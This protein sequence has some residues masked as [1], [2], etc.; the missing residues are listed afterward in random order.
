M[1]KTFSGYKLEGRKKFQGLNISIENERGSVRRGTDPNG[2]EWATF[3]HI[4]YGYIRTTEGVDGDHVDCYIGTDSHSD[5]VFI[6]HQQDPDTKKYDED[7][8]M[9]GF[10]DPETALKAYRRQYDRPGYDQSMDAVNMGTFKT[11]LKERYG[12]KLKPPKNAETQKKGTLVSPVEKAVSEYHFDS[13]APNRPTKSQKSAP[14]RILKGF[15]EGH[16]EEEDDE[17]DSTPDNAFDEGFERDRKNDE[18]KDKRPKKYRAKMQKSKPVS[19]GTL[20]K[21]GKHVK[22]GKGK[23][24]RLPKSDP[25]YRGGST[26]FKHGEVRTHIKKVPHEA[27]KKNIKSDIKDTGFKIDIE[28]ATVSNKNFRKVI[29]TGQES[30]LVLMSLKPGEEIGMEVHPT[31]DQFFR[32]DGG[33]GKAIIGGKGRDIKNG[34]AFIAPRG[35]EHNVIAGPRGLKL[36]TI[37]SPANYKED[38]VEKENMEKAKRMPV[39]TVSH[40]YQKVAEGKWRRLADRVQS[41]KEGVKKTTTDGLKKIA[42]NLIVHQNDNSGFSLN[43][44]LSELK[45]RLGNVDFWSFRSDIERRA[46]AMGKSLEKAYARQH[47]VPIEKM[48][49]RKG[50]TFAQTFWVSREEAKQIEERRKTVPMEQEEPIK[51][52]SKDVRFIM[53]AEAA[54]NYAPGSKRQ[55]DRSMELQAQLFPHG[56][57][58]GADTATIMETAEAEL[59]HILELEERGIDSGRDWYTKAME[60]TRATLSQIHP[61]LVDDTEWNKLTVLIAVTSPGLKPESNLPLGLKMYEHLKKTGKIPTTN[62]EGGKWPGKNVKAQLSIMNSFARKLGGIDQF[63]QWLKQNSTGRE[64]QSIKK[65]SSLKVDKEYPNSIIFGPKVG[66]F[67]RNMLGE[68]QYLTIDRW[69]ARSFYRWSNKIEPVLNSMGAWEVSVKLTAGEREEMEYVLGTLSEEYNLTMAETQAM[70]WYYE[71]RLYTKLKGSRKKG[72]KETAYDEAANKAYEDYLAS[73]NAKAG[74]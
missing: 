8:V 16:Y 50:K 70:L 42:E 46:V 14:Q 20:S 34:D 53:E 43:D 6:V 29:A 68:H 4:P 47:L 25:R 2:H 41:L 40:G 66:V 71:K 59:Q 72:E 69:A 74:G 21:D 24:V 22:A 3:M 5:R 23:W 49:T 54:I 15:S 32:I 26:G 13:E 18:L 61:E 65:D 55:I 36:Y 62:P 56:P 51:A 30:Q 48:V 44:V 31:I 63:M 39:G 38:T 10:R 27:P 67:Y 60:R 1:A 17:E 7:K 9:L 19:V 57:M 73:R 11:M 58:T 45:D 28:E 37:Y 12:L 64:L 52:K 35:S 33:S